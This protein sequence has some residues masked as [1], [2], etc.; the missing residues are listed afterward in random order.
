MSGG[1]YIDEPTAINNVNYL[2]NILKP[3]KTTNRDL[4][5]IILMH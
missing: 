2:E 5:V 3:T 1:K 4:P